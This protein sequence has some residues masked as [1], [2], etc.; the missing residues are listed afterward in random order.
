MNPISYWLC[1][2][3]SFYGVPAIVVYQKYKMVSP[4]APWS[5]IREVLSV[6]VILM[7]LVLAFIPVINIMISFFVVAN[8]VIDL[9]SQLFVAKWL[10]FK[11]FSK[12]K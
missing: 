5:M 10:R 9:G 8:L 3:I 7:T 6:F 12:S 2:A 4:I 1:V 11:P